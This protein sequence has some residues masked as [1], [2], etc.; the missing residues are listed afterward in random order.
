M[1]QDG[2]TDLDQVKF[3]GFPAVSETFNG[4]LN[5]IRRP[6]ITDEH[7]L[8][9]IRNVETQKDVLEGNHGGG[10]GMRSHGF[11][12]GTGT[13]SRILKG[14]NEKE[15]TLGVIVQNNYGS[16][17]DLQIDGVPV[18]KML[19]SK[20]AQSKVDVPPVPA[21]GKAVEGSCLVLIITDAPL[22]PHQLQRIAQ[23][24]GMGLSQ[25][26]SHGVGRHF[27]G[28][29]FMALPTG[30]KPEA[31]ANWDGMTSLPPALEVESLQAVKSVVLDML[32]VATAEATEEAALDAMT[33][34]ETMTGFRGFRTEALPREEV[35]VLL[36][37]HGRGCSKGEDMSSGKT[38][39]NR[40][41][42]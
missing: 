17:G 13:S 32:F 22:L 1:D 20:K 3:Y 10:T 30:N 5:D 18:G 21:A 28:E 37:K 2:I 12:A 33:S 23:R 31:P 7:V 42:I 38:Q 39:E 15:Y 41:G 34:A 14:E 25:V 36:K 16:P 4:L 19:W 8:T 29:F 24:A 11:K 40:H 6:A 27:S 26:S 35:E 9:A